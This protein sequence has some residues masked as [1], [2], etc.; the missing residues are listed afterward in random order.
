MINFSAYIPRDRRHALARNETLPDHTSGAVLFADIA[1]FTPLTRA[2]AQTLGK[3]RGAEALLNLLNPL[4]EALIEPVHRYGGSV[5][6]FAGDSIICWFDDHPHLA[7][8]VEPAA[9]RAVAAGLAMQDGMT[10]FANV[11]T[12]TEISLSVKAGI[13]AGPARR[14]LVGDPAIQRLD[15]LAGELLVRMASAEKQA[16]QGELVLSRE[17][18]VSLGDGLRVKE[19]RDGE[20]YAVIAGLAVEVEPS[21]WPPLPEEVLPAEVS[22]QWMLPAVYDQ[23][24]SGADSLGDLRPVTP[25]ML[26][27]GGID[28]DGDPAAGEKLDAFISWVQRAIHHHGGVLLQLT[29]GDKGAFIYAPFGAPRAHENDPAR[30]MQA[31]LALR[32]LPTDLADFITPLQI[33][34]T[35][36][37]VWTGNCGGNGRYTYGVMGSDVNLAARLMSQA[38]PGQILVSGR[39]SQ[40]PGFRL[41]PIGDL[42][43]KGFEQP[44]PA[45]SLLG[46]LLAEEQIFSTP[47]VGRKAELQ[48]LVEFTQPL[49]DGKLAGTAIIYGE[50]GIGK[51]RLASA[52]RQQLNQSGIS[53]FIGQTDQILRQAFNPF[54]YWL[55]GYFAQ[56]PDNTVEQNKTHFT[57]RL[58]SLIVNLQSLAAPPQTLIAELTR[59]QSFLGALFGLHWGDS[60]YEQLDDPKLRYQ[61]TLTAIKTLIL[62]ESRL[63]PVVVELQ[64]GHWLDKS[65]RDLLLTISRQ[66][67]AYPLLI[68]ITS[69][70]HDDGSRPAFALDEDM[71]TLTLDLDALSREALAE[72]AVAILDGS[73]APELLTLLWERSHANPFF[74]EQM[75]LHFRET[76]AL[77]QTAV[78]DWALITPPSDLPADVN[79]MLIARIDRLAQQVKQVVQVAAVLGREFDVQLLS[80]ML[81][82]DVLPEVQRAESEQIWALLHEL[83]YIFKHALLRDAAYEMQLSVRLRDLHY[84]AAITTEQVYAD[85]LP[86]YYDTL[87]YH[88]HATYQLGAETALEKAYE[89]LRKAGE[90]AQQNYANDTAL[91][92][93]NKLLP[94][95]TDD[96]EKTQIHL[97]RGEVRQ[98]LGNWNAAESDYRA[99][100]E[101]ATAYAALQATAQFALGR[102][103]RLR[104]EYAPALNWLTQAQET[105]TH[106][107]NTAGLA[108]ALVETSILWENKSDYDQA[109][110]IAQTGLA[111]AHQ[112]SNAWVVAQALTSLGQVAFNQGN[113]AEARTL[114]AESLAIWR[115]NE[116]K[117]GS[118]TALNDLAKISSIQGDDTTARALFEESLEMRR[119]IGDKK[120]MAASF[121]N[122][123]IIA[124]NQSD[125]ARSLALHQ[126]SLE[127]KRELGDKLGLATSL[128]N[129][130]VVESDQG[131]HVAAR[132]RFEQ[133][134]ALGRELDD[135]N[136]VANALNSLGEV[137]SDQEDHTE[138]R[139]LYTESLALRREIGD[140]WGIA[141]TLSNLGFTAYALGDY[142]AAQTLL[143]E[144]LSLTQEIDVQRTL[145]FIQLVL[146]MV[147]L[148]KH[149][150][151]ARAYLLDSLRTSQQIRSPRNKAT[152]LVGVAGLAQ[153][154]GNPRLA[155]QLLG[156]AEA[157]FSAREV[158]I[159]PRVKPLYE[160]TLATAHAQL[161]E[162][163]FQSAWAEG[164]TWSLAEAVELALG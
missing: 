146:G 2:F 66:V 9:M 162:E 127:L 88:Y 164:S 72:Q 52:L 95:L 104:G 53:W 8:H 111:L 25:L 81:R 7:D 132:V 122:L 106:L 24:R 30:A 138:A 31:A 18:A 77:G 145:S 108:Q 137:A 23:L 140:K 141:T 38:Q 102:L 46:E 5:V 45:Y 117:R 139:K 44:V 128:H 118:A 10:Q 96:N 130:G 109:R 144:S 73:V 65:S 120:G 48:Q 87:A 19:W 112:T 136:G 63:R 163:A 71:P 100:L 150:P 69:R 151:E 93:Y 121:N 99:A 11:P 34:L 16:Q 59:T 84:L 61:N 15:T 105:H 152:N 82:A 157:A 39:M 75:L 113:Y 43:V 67:S 91:E 1:G 123:A 142:G 114:Y 64:D 116:N 76:D 110:A 50:P 83:Q 160:Q 154:E 147:A 97:K 55:K 49:F 156:A 101:S 98:L 41:H 13:S 51:S 32:D 103:Y 135:K 22:R 4:F 17:V 35:R 134:L 148:A 21:P 155:A 26:S 153:Q 161:G 107:N 70:Y 158:V 115:A 159:A 90:V 56:S 60:L 33:G 29:I 125:Y 78:G 27:F 47:M 85:Q 6:G 62:A 68:I 126:A 54:V 133:S 37:E 36:G 92:Y 131:H 80:D 40:Y 58:E 12:G 20:R 28:F 57:D 129:L 42:T 86:N 94:L 119:A 14:F 124:R 3:K 79:A 143:T 89:Y 74:A 149:A